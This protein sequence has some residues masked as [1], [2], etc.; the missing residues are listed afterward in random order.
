MSATTDPPVEKLRS[1]VLLE[2]LVDQGLDAVVA[3]VLLGGV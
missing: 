2:L 1:E 3:T